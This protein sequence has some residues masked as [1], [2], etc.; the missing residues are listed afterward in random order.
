LVHAQGDETGGDQALEE[1]VLSVQGVIYKKDLPPF[2]EKI[3]SE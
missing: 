3:R 2:L 1:V